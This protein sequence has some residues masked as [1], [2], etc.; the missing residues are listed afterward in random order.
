MMKNSSEHPALTME[1]EREL[2]AAAQ[3]GDQR[4]F[5]TLAK[6]AWGR[7]FAVCLSITGSRADAEDALQNAL[8]AAWKNIDKFD[9]RARFSTWA[10][11]IAS[12]AALQIVRSRREIPD[13]DAG[14]DA[15]APTSAVDSQ[16][17]SAMVVRNALARLPDEFR[18]VI[19]LREYAGMSYNEIAVHQKIPVQTVKSRINRARGKLLAELRAAGVEPS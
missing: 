12:N 19:V 9:G 1:D 3:A 8:T 15:I 17:T 10:Y 2:L 18:E 5:G 6:Q 11:R 14:K 7:M 16:V 13:E 4:A